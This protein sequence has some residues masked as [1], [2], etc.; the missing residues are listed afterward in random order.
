M[1]KLNEESVKRLDEVV[2]KN[3]YMRLD[4]RGLLTLEL[5]DEKSMQECVALTVHCINEINSTYHTHSKRAST[6]EGS[7]NE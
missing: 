3:Y 7:N 4:E 5:T 2:T 1:P 6:S